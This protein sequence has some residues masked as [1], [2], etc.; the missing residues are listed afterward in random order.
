MYELI[1]NYH[2]FRYRETL[3]HLQ[4]C[5]E[6]IDA[7]ITNDAEILAKVKLIDVCR[8]IIAH[9]DHMGD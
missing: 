8:D 9:E 2:E 6:N 3:E 5:Y 1:S 7:E 4:E